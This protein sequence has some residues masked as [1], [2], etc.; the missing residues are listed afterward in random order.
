M[1]E[2][3]TDKL[4]WKTSSFTNPSGNCVQWAN[5]PNGGRALRDSKDPN[6]PVLKFT[7]QEVAAFNLAVDAGEFV[8]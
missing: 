5:L 2:I 6:G 1:A 3:D 7:H 4:E 8:S